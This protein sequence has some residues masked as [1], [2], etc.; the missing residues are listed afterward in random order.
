[1]WREK[2]SIY[3]NK[4]YRVNFYVYIISWFRLDSIRFNWNRLAL[5]VSW[6]LQIRRL[7]NIW[8]L[9]VL[10]KILSDIFCVYILLYFNI[11]FYYI[12]INLRILFTRRIH[13]SVCE[14]I[15][16]KTAIELV[17]PDTFTMKNCTIV[18]ASVS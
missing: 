1:M 15:M 10:I 4:P 16:V 2:R 13:N 6:Y 18:S 11:N 7:E 17:F 9:N 5:L 8:I 12:S 14:A 3:R